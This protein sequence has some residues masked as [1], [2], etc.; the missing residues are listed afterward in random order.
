MELTIDRFELSKSGK[1]LNDMKHGDS[2][3]I[4]ESDYGFGYIYKI[5]S[6]FEFWEIPMY[7]GEPYFSKRF[8]VSED[9]ARECVKYIQSIS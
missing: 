5:N 6:D 3:F 1:E 7:G 2:I 4:P 9:G 8:S